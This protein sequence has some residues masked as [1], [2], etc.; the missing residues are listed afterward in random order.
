MN[1]TLNPVDDICVKTRRRK[2]IHQDC[3]D[4]SSQGHDEDKKEQRKT[5]Y[6]CE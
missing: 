3:V 5:N 2:K 4:A 6:I 1:K